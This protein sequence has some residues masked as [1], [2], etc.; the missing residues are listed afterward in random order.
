MPFF[1]LKHSFTAGELSP[2]MNDRIDFDRYRNG[3]KTLKNMF[4]VTQGPAIRRPGLKFVYDLNRIGF[5]TE[6]GKIRMIPFIFNEIQAYVMVFYQHEDGGIRMVLAT[7]DS[8]GAD[9][10]VLGSGQPCEYDSE[11]SR[12]WEGDT[13][14]PTDFVFFYPDGA[15]V[16]AIEVWHIADA[17][18]ARTE[19][20]ET[21]DYTVAYDDPAGEATVTVLSNA[22]TDALEDGR[23]YCTLSISVPAILRN[24]VVTIYLPSDW[25]LDD[26]DWAQSGD[27]M[28]FAQ[29]DLNPHI[30]RRHDHTCWELVSVTFA[31][32]PKDWSDEYGWP[33]RVTFHQQR[34]C[35]GANKLRR[36]TIWMS[37]AG[38][39][40]DFGVS[41]PLLDS[42]AVTFTLDSGTQNRIQWISSSKSLHVGTLGNEWTVDGND[43]SALTPDNILARRQTN[44]GSEPNKPLMVGI[45]T[46][47]FQRPVRTVN[48]FA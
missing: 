47:L 37:K 12:D 45:T 5:D 21:T 22:T 42:D 2:L 23:I 40:G 8:K 48:E 39:F 14:L 7:T 36:Q 11:S 15:S 28:Y 20:T 3:C 30:I 13:T 9:G 27:E 34:L 6:V 44:S 4:C 26:F 19:L 41:S 24:E 35:F 29:P 38:D 18:Q 33:E 1:R 43:Q 17:D 46:L 16:T 32:Q 25:N 10:L 31:N